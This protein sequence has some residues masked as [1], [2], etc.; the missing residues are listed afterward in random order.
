MSR[1]LIT[2][3][4]GFIGKVLARELLKKNYD[5]TLVTRDEQKARRMFEN[6]VDI[7]EWDMASSTTPPSLSSDIDYVINLMGENLGA[8]RWSAKQKKK[9][10]SSRIDGTRTLISA[11]KDASI[12]LKAF[13]SASAIGIYPVN[14]ESPLDEAVTETASSFLGELCRRW[15]EEVLKASAERIAIVRIGVVLGAGGGLIA[16]MRPIF[17]LGLGGR[18]GRGA[19]MM[20]WIH[21]QDLVN[22]FVE[23]LENEQMKGPV[24]ATSPYPITNAVFSQTLAKTLSRPC[25]FPVPSFVLKAAMGEMSTLALDSQKIMPKKLQDMGFSFQFGEI[26]KALNNL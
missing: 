3:G 14:R 23:V 13:I 1:V 15:E 22:I 24:N 21:I 6:N 19:Q 20:S 9:L 2:G 5:I 10:E 17:A 12:S 11:L 26:Q 7:L 8:K 25:L 4:T 16:K 18:I